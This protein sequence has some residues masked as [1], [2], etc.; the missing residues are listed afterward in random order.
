MKKI[1]F[2]LALVMTMNFCA[3]AQTDGF[4]NWNYNIENSDRY[5]DVDNSIYFSLPAAHGYENDTN[6]PLGSGLLI[7][8][9]LG[10]GYTIKKKRS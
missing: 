10:V 5:I 3:N 8:T 9:V 6:A 2:A 1:I 4:F 7:L